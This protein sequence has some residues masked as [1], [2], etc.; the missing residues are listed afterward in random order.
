MYKRKT[1]VCFHN[2]RFIYMLI[3]YKRSN[4]NLVC[5][6]DFFFCYKKKLND[7]A[8]TLIFAMPLYTQYHDESIIIFKQK[9]K[10]KVRQK[11]NLKEFDGPHAKIPNPSNLRTKQE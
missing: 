11:Q 2:T 7:L 10:K 5:I 9:Q 4:K 1:L 6:N 3:N 8:Y